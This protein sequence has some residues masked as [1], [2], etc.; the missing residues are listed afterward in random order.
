MK[1][2]AGVQLS[3]ITNVAASAEG[4]QM[5]GMFNLVSQGDLKG[6]Q[7]AGI[8]N[9]VRGNTDGWQLG[10]LYNSSDG[11][12]GL[13]IAGIANVAGDVSKAQIAGIINISSG[14]VKGLQLALINVADTISGTP[15]GLLNFVRR[16][17]NRVE[18]QQQ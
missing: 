7:I 18:N 6:F 4:C 16:G 11:R 5:S 9:S 8:G 3:G 12:A 15:I 17:Y 10:G 14:E 2:K 13:Q 1:A